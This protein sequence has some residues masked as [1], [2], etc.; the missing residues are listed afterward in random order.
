MNG[1][2]WNHLRAFHVTAQ[3]GSL[4]AAARELGL[5]QPTLSRQ[6]RALEESLGVELFNRVG[7]RLTLTEV[8]RDLLGHISRM[9][10]AA[11][12]A[13]LAASGHVQELSGR[14]CISAT[15]SFSV[16]VLPELIERIREEAPQITIEVS[17][18]DQLSNLHKM[19]ADIAIRNVPPDRAGLVGE[20]IHDTEVGFYASEAWIS[21][22][23]LPKTLAE[24]AG[25][26]LICFDDTAQFSTFLQ[27]IGIPISAED[28]RLHSSSSVVV[29]E[30][31]KR[32]LGVGGML[33]EVAERTPGIVKLVPD[34]PPISV[35]VWLITHQDLQSSPRI[36]LVYKIL[37]EGLSKL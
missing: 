30:M 2:D 17:A 10:E 31:V 15:D 32:G 37:S 16:Y 33:R 25:V 8:G 13:I 29:W 12:A 18:T 7:R 34:M 21:Q 27:K 24:L 4:S 11:E 23:G 5:T 36:R 20:H 14:V 19:E 26:D 35:P 9:D 22:N 28:F 3:R 1:A 6:V